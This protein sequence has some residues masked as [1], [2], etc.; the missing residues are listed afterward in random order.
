MFILLAHLGELL[1]EHL[2]LLLLQQHGAEAAKVRRAGAR[3]L[4]GELLRPGGRVPLRLDVAG[5]PG[6]VER[7]LAR[8]A[9]DLGLEVRQG[10]PL[11]RDDLARHARDGRRPVH[12]RAPVVD[13]VHDGAQLARVLAVVD[14]DH[15][16]DLDKSGEGHGWK[17]EKKKEG[18]G[19]DDHRHEWLAGWLCK[20]LT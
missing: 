9:P 15:A 2:A 8:P 3:L 7:L 20:S 11:E 1:L 12:E 5:R 13:H 4:R 10:Q 19:V 17:R 16:A 14:Q 6:L 18:C